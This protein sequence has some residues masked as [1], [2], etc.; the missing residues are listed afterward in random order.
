MKVCFMMW[1]MF[2]CSDAHCGVLFHVVAKFLTNL[3]MRAILPVEMIVDLAS[4]SPPYRRT[5]LLNYFL[6]HHKTLRLA[7]RAEKITKPF[8]PTTVPGVLAHPLEVFSDKASA[9]MGFKILEDDWRIN[10]EKFG[11]RAHPN[12]V[13][14][15]D[16]IR[17]NRVES[18]ERGKVVFGYLGSRMSGKGN[19]LNVPD[20]PR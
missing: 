18:V 2:W 5:Q 4:A 15:M 14:L 3:G 12:V 17:K 19:I 16:W 13:E 20:W 7:Y 6:E 8:L 9:I 10:A 11:V 1:I